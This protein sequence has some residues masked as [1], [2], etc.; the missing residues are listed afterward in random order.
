MV[1]H[2]Q[3][4]LYCDIG[5]PRVHVLSGAGPAGICECQS[6]VCGFSLSFFGGKT[7]YSKEM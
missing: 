7:G 3:Y 5:L 6:Q 1:Q 4:S 2:S